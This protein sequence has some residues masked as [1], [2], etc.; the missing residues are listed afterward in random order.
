MK[1]GLVCPYNMFEFAGGVQEVVLAQ[2]RELTRLGHSVKIIT[3][4][5]KNF[6]KAIPPHTILLGR[7]TKM[8]TPFHTM[9]DMSVSVDVAEIDVMLEKEN[10]DLLHFHEPWVPM[11]SRQILTRSTSINVATFHAKLPETLMSRSI[12]SAVT[13]YTKSVLKFLDGLSA[14]SEAAA[15]YVRTLTDEPITIVPNGIDLKSYRFNKRKKINP[16]QIT[17]I[18]RLEKRKG[19][20]YLL[21]AFARLQKRNP[22]VQLLIAGKGVK[23]DNLKLMVSDLRLK[24]VEFLGFVSNEEK[25]ELMQTSSIVCSPALYGES[26]G[27]ILLEAMA[28][29][30]V[31]VA[32]N[33][34][35]Y[36][37]V[38]TD[39]GQ[40][41]L[42]D[43]RESEDF[44]NSLQLLMEDEQLRHIW[45]S[46]ALNHVKQFDNA[47]IAKRYDQFYKDVIKTL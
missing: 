26:F 43:P 38:L 25:I 7:S 24:N 21:L 1:V 30:A 15:T 40:L 14:V 19:V 44:A 22:N 6:T 36:R 17:Y 35:G 37:S 16:N 46:W 42:V 45:R 31:V 29:G 28:C 12:V 32:G 23:E 3:P 39:R 13:P 34:P 33:N 20:E 10:F 8:N 9:V 18:G 41:S 2:Q 27:I 5:P 47:V 11:L 4:R